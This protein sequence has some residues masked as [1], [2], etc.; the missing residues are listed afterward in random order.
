MAGAAAFVAVLWLALGRLEPRD[1]AAILL[2]STVLELLA[3]PFNAWLSRRW[4]RAAD[5][6][7]LE[8]T[9]DR[10]AFRSA[11]VRLAR[12]NLADLDPP[13]IVYAWLFSHPTAPERLSLVEH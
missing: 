11:H 9:G 8:L 5:R 7:S 12:A 4:E 3:A 10:D 13:R 2:L 6:F 1:A